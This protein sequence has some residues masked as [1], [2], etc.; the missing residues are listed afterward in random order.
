MSESCIRSNKI[1]LVSMMTVRWR[2]ACIDYHG[3]SWL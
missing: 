3:R 2:L 1:L